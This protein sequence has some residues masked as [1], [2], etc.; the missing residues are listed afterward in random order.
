MSTHTLLSQGQFCPFIKSGAWIPKE[1]R[2]VVSAGKKKKRLI[3]KRKM[4]SS[5]LPD[6]DA[7]C[8]LFLFNYFCDGRIPCVSIYYSTAYVYTLIIHI[9]IYI[10]ISYSRRKIYGR[11]EYNILLSHW[12][13]IV[14]LVSTWEESVVWRKRYLSYMLFLFASFSQTESFRKFARGGSQDKFPIIFSRPNS[15]HRSWKE[16]E[17]E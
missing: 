15:L 11:G 10:I 1:A 4:I 16:M 2:V 12:F 7:L 14:R 17:K 3:I 6:V 5:L 9:Y 13:R 8:L